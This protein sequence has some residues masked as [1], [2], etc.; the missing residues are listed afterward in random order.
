MFIQWHFLCYMAIAGELFPGVQLF[1]LVI[2][3]MD[4]SSVILVVNPVIRIPDK[5]ST[6]GTL[7]SGQYGNRKCAAENGLCNAQVL[8]AD[9]YKIYLNEEDES[10]SGRNVD[11][12]Y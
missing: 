2:P 5:I 4:A 3:K 8:L 6:S 1:F 10:N 7:H 9:K 11:V 12:N